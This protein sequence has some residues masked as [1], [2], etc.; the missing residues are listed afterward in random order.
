MKAVWLKYI[1]VRC[2]HFGWGQDVLD[3]ANVVDIVSGDHADYMLDG[4][5]AALGMLAVLLPLIG[6]QRFEERKI[7]FAHY[8][9]QFDGFARI[10]L[11]VVS[12]DDPGVLIV[13]LDGGSGGSEDGAHAPADY[14]F[15]VS[16]VSEDF[17]DGPFVECGALAE[18]GGGDALDEASEF[19]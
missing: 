13:G 18:F 10:A 3:L 5:L 9:V 11:F 4:F 17:G 2:G 14:D 19:F 7:C 15:D 8:A 12:G 16:E 1:M 6:G